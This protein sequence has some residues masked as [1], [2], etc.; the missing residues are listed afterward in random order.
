MM[1]NTFMK[2]TEQG[3]AAIIKADLWASVEAPADA[4]EDIPGVPP[5]S[6]EELEAMARYFGE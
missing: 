4:W 3:E 2:N 6:G 1:Y 5:P